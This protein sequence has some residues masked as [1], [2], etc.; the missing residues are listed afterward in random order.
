MSNTKSYQLYNKICILQ[1]LSQYISPI[2]QILKNHIIAIVKE[3]DKNE[4]AF[5][6]PENIENKSINKIIIGISKDE[7][8]KKINNLFSKYQNHQ[9][10]QSGI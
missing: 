5:I 7:T 10:F 1:K 6:Q 3:S 9:N 8:I 4:N 2:Q